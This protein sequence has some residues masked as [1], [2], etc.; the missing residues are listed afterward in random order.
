MVAIAQ[1]AARNVSGTVAP[2]ARRRPQARF[3]IAYALLRWLLAIAWQLFPLAIPLVNLD[4]KLSRDEA[5]AKAEALAAEATWRPRA[6]A[7]RRLRAR[8]VTQ[9]YVEL[10]GGGKAASRRWSRAPC[11]RP[12]C[13]TCGSSSPARSTRRC[14]ASPDGALYGFSR[15]AAG[16]VRA[17]PATLALSADAAREI[18]RGVR[19]GLGRRSRP[20]RAR[21]DAA[22]AHYRAGRS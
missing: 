7:G 21:P 9:N 14:C 4:I 13:G 2:D 6:H 18:A 16:D 20:Y 22:A 5:M 8:R 15:Q 12:I 19:A 3:W 17:D 1:L 10:E 11:M